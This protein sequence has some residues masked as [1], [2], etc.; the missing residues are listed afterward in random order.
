MRNLLL[1]SLLLASGV[2]MAADGYV[3]D[4]YD[5]DSGK[6]TLPSVHTTQGIYSVEMFLDKN[7][8][9]SLR[10]NVYDAKLVDTQ[11]VTLIGHDLNTKDNTLIQPSG[12][13]SG[14]DINQS[15]DAGDVLVG[16][17]GNDIL[18]GG[19]GRDVLLG[20]AGDDIIIGGTEDFGGGA[21]FAD[22]GPGN[23]TF[24]WAPGDGSDYFKGGEGEADVVIFG[25]IGENNGITPN[26]A[27]FAVATDKNFDGIFIDPITK[28]P[29]VNV[30]KSPGFCEVIDKQSH[31][32]E[33]TKLGLDHLV[34][35]FVRSP[36]DSF[37]AGTQS[38]DNG[39]RVT[40]HLEGVE[41]LVCTQR[42]GNT[43]E[44]LDL[45]TSP[46]SVSN[47]DKLPTYIRDMVL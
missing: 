18:I 13:L 35:F 45:T 5:F 8:A 21:D 34:R 41:Y 4:Y 3:S 11:G 40:L 32:D 7:Y 37:A 44:V 23:D 43:I 17:A 30:T 20:N 22:G 46:P 27:G 2:S 42:E 36:A 28:Q 15:L 38:T 9:S 25:L 39:L 16:T 1:S 33:M 47:L 14:G 10:F 31:L 29:K 12:A 19:M 6:L 24:L 26:E